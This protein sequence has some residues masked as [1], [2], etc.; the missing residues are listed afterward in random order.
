VRPATLDELLESCAAIT[1]HVPLA[2]GA[3]PLIGAREL[4]LM[5]RGAFVVNTARSGLVDGEALMAALESG[6]LGGAAV[7][8]IDV[9]PP[10]AEHP[11]PRHSRLIVN[12]HA[13]WYSP[14]SEQEVYRRATLSVRAVLEGREP[15]GAVVRPSAG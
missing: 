2:P 1:L 4:A 6:R 9:E 14:E 3:A 5:P 15:D 12:P 13:A 10:T 7:D 8:V 11:A